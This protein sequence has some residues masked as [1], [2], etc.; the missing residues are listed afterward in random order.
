[1]IKVYKNFLTEHE[2]GKIH[3]SVLEHQQDWKTYSDIKVYGNSYFRHLLKTN[4]NADTAYSLYKADRDIEFP[5]LYELLL[6]RFS[7]LLQ[8]QY[9]S[10][11]CKPAFQIVNQATPRIWHYDD[12]KLRYPYK[13]EFPDYTDSSYFDNYYTLTIMISKGDFTYDYYPETYSEY[14]NEPM[15]YCRK[16]HG[17]IGDECDC[18]LK[19]YKTIKYSVGDLVLTKG[20]YLH[21][22]GS[23]K[24]SLDEQRMTIQGHIVAKNNIHYLY[25]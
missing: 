9:T 19:D 8:C 23:S 21:R 7:N 14:K 22:V 25:W 18:D 17:L 4:F 15:Y 13:V 6:E 20:R 3:S 12:E 24:Y 2:C 11:F 1:M 16:H 10:N 5:W